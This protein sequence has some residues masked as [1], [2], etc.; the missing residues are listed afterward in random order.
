[1]FLTPFVDYKLVSFTIYWLFACFLHHLSSHL[2]SKQRQH[3][4][5]DLSLTHH[6]TDLSLTH[7]RTDLSLTHHRT[8]L[9]LTHHRTRV[10]TMAAQMGLTNGTPFLSLIAIGIMAWFI[11]S[12]FMGVYAAAV[13]TI[14]LSFLHDSEVGMLFVCMCTCFFLSCMTQR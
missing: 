6:R 10:Q 7:H 8:D 4:Q 11:G 14:F 3:C 2:S 1:M 12:S 9:S 13:D 5:A